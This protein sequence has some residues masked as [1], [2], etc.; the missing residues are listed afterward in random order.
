MFKKIKNIFFLISFFTFIFL[1]S[2]HYFSDQNIIFTN[3]SRSF[4]SWT[5]NK[6]NKNLPILTNDTNNIIV[7]KNDLEEFKK[8]KKKRIWEKLIS[9]ENQ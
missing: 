4:Y 8:K 6:D 5:Q 9:N 3:K 1:V 2:R 7:Y